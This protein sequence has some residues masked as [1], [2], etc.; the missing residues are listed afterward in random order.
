MQTYVR[1]LG[2]TYAMFVMRIGALVCALLV[3]GGA[4]AGASSVAPQTYGPVRAW[5]GTKIRS[6]DPIRLAGA[7][8]ESAGGR[9]QVLSNEKTFTRWAYVDKTASIYRAANTS[10]PRVGRLTWYTPDGFS[11]IY[12]LL[13]ASWDASGQEWVELRIP[14][15]PNG[16][17][18]WVERSALGPFHLTHLLLVVNRERLRMYL[19]DRGRR[20]WSAPVGVGKPSTPTPTGHF[21]IDERFQ[22]TDP[23]SGYYP[24]AFGTT[25]YSTLTDWPGGGVV[26]I[27]G[28]YY[29]AQG[30]PG[31]ISHGCIR[32]EV[33]DDFWLAEHLKLG[34][35]VHVV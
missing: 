35:P 19:Y 16:R 25:D 26:G 9:D 33:A 3:A 2:F 34:T 17:T 18:G 10:S 8:S 7:A 24:Y 29:D 11:S 28:P 5:G 1:N 22:I 15:R 14:G 32:L 12:L 30:I 27:H 20:I 23:S 31:Y 6:L 4:T 21:W 13:R